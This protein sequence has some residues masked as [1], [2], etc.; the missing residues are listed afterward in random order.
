[1]KKALEYIKKNFLLWEDRKVLNH[2]LFFYIMCYIN[3]FY[4]LLIVWQ[5]ENINHGEKHLQVFL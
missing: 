2:S 4:F 3:E 5:I 1:M